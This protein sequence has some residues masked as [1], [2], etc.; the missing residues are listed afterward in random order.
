MAGKRAEGHGE[1]AAR[2]PF[3]L[4][5]GLP[6]LCGR[7]GAFALTEFIGGRTVSYYL[8]DRDRYGGR[9]PCAGWGA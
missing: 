1:G 4:G 3:G 6:W 2:W 5:G 9:W 8:R 7:R